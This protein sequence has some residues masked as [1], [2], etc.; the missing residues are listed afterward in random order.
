MHKLRYCL[1]EEIVR[2]SVSPFHSLYIIHERVSV[3]WVSFLKQQ[4]LRNGM[5][6]LCGIFEVDQGDRDGCVVVFRSPQQIPWQ[7]IVVRHCCCVQPL[8]NSGDFFQVE[9]AKSFRWYD[10]IVIDPRGF[11]LWVENDGKHQFTIQLIVEIVAEIFSNFLLHDG[12][13]VGTGVNF[14][15]V[16]CNPDGK[17]YRLDWCR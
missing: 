6:E 14:G 10:R 3:V 7:Q 9:G 17:Q 11:Q 12:T 1:Q 16:I 8:D 15:R 13:D 2:Q 4:Q 5:V